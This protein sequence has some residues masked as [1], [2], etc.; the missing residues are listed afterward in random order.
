MTM[1][2]TMTMT[3][4]SLVYDPTT[5]ACNVVM[6][7]RQYICILIP[8]NTTC[9]YKKNTF[10]QTMKHNRLSQVPLNFVTSS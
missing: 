1:T 2:M 3:I 6:V 5:P 4:L 9:N 10:T 8:A 7:S